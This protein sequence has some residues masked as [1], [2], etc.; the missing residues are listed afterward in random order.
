MLRNEAGAG[1]QIDYNALN[2]G[3][4]GDVCMFRTLFLMLL[5]VP[6]VELYVLIQVGGVIGA[7]P[8]ILLTI[9]TAIVGAAL[10]RSQ[11]LM[12]LQQLQVQIAQGVRPALTLA[13]GGLII[14]GGMLLLVPGFLTDGLGLALLMP[15]LRR[16]LAAKLV[17]RSVAQGAGQ[18][19]VIIEG[20]VISRESTAPPALPASDQDPADKP[21]ERR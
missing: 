5:L 20:E 16:W 4:Q 8:T 15:P 3:A 7:L 17:S 18:T 12:T 10:M 13:E 19:T 9:F 21:P 2:K 14:V 1:E 6:A 11:G